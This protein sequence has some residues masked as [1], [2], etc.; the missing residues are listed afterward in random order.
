MICEQVYSEQDRDS[1]TVQ[2]ESPINDT[3]Q[4]RRKHNIEEEEDSVI[5]S[6]S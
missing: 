3:S 2:T 4:V 1:A 5:P 6:R